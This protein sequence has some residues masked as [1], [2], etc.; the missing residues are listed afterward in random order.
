MNTKK[1]LKY[2]ALGSVLAGLSG[3]VSYKNIAHNIMS[4][5]PTW[6]TKKEIINDLPKF[7]FTRG[8]YDGIPNDASCIPKGTDLN[9]IYLGKQKNPFEKSKYLPTSASISDRKSV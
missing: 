2:I 6:Q 7:L 9:A 5:H 4:H 3:I 1:I 8:D